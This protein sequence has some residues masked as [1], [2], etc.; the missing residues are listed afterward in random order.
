MMTIDDFFLYLENG[1]SLQ[2]GILVGKRI[3][4]VHFTDEMLYDV[5]VK[6]GEN[7]FPLLF[8]RYYPGQPPYYRTWIE[9]SQIQDRIQYSEQKTFIYFSSTLEFELISLLSSFLQVGEKIFISY[10]SDQETSYGLTYGFPV[11]T[12]RL[13]F[14]LFK[15]GFTWFK[16]W[17]FPEGGLEG[18]QKLQGEKPLDLKSKHRHLTQIREELLIFLNTDISPKNRYTHNIRARSLRL[19]KNL[20][21]GINE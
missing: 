12:T 8:L 6:L 14:T 20:H 5:S 9:L 21:N 1:I 19:I 2:H 10:D 15:H 4:S 17:Y 3:K 16:D 7:F 11:V 18:G 13:G